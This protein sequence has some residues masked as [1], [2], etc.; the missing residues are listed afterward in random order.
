MLQSS[1]EIVSKM[2]VP[3][4]RWCQIKSADNS[5]VDKYDLFDVSSYRYDD[6]LQIFSKR[7]LPSSI[8]RITHVIKVLK[9]AWFRSY[10]LHNQ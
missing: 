8:C 9:I 10:M 1:R 7:T 4:Y 5:A 3:L 6:S 2:M